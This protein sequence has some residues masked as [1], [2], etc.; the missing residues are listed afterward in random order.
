MTSMNKNV[1]I[2]G[3]NRGIG[4]ALAESFIKEGANVMISSHEKDSLETVAKEIGA[5]YCVADVRKEQDIRDLMNAAVGKLGGVDIWINN[6]GIMPKF[7]SGELIDMDKATAL[8]ETNVFGYIFGCRTARDYMKNNGGGGTVI[9]ILSSAALDATRGENIKMYAASK[10]AVR[11]F[12]DAFRKEVEGL[13]I[14]VLAIYPGGTKTDLYAE[15]TPSNL[16]E[17]MSPERVAKKTIE[18]L[19]SD[20]PENELIIKRPTA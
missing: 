16:D 20:S 18:F 9:N 17:F 7:P 4:K 10:W 12:T 1:V 13:G 2:T 11:G 3:G 8:F 5:E 19:K 15:N 6:A 14:R